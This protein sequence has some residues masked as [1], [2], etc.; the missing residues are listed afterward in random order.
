MKPQNRVYPVKPLP[1]L[2]ETKISLLDKQI[3]ILALLFC[4]ML[5]ITGFMS[6]G[7]ASLRSI[8]IG[9]AGSLSIKSIGCGNQQANGQTDINAAG[10]AGGWTGSLVGNAPL[11]AIKVKI[12]NVS[13]AITIK[14]TASRNQGVDIPAALQATV[15]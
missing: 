1:P 14:E 12:R 3:A 15:K 8:E 5:I 6:C 2:Y 10:A 7:S 4:L 11:Q 9:S 13:G